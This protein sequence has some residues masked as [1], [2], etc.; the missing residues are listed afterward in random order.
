MSIKILAINPGGT[1][2]KIGF[3]EDNQPVF[4][5]TIEH[6]SEEL[7]RFKHANNQLDMRFNSIYDALLKN[8]VDVSALTACVGRGGFLP[9]VEAGGYRVNDLMID[10]LLNRCELEHASSLGAVLADRF[11]QL[12]K[13]RAHAYIYDAE[14]LN[15]LPP[16]ARI[17]GV[18]S[19]ERISLCHVLNMRAVCRRVAEALNSRYED[20]NFIIIHMGGGTS[21]SAHNKGR[22]IEAMPDD[23]GPF[24]VERSGAIANKYIVNMCY[25]KPMAEVFTLLRKN[26]GV[27]SYLGTNDGREVEQM[28]ADGDQYA[29][30]IYEAMSYQ[31]ARATGDMYAVLEG[32][33]DGI[34]LTGGL[35]KSQ[36]MCSMIQKRVEFMAPVHVVP[37]EYELEALAEGAYR[38]VTNQEEA[39][40]Y[41]E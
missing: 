18:K 17:S 32:Q 38:I 40:E 14:S 33:V 28:I 19:I 39:R 5:K 31:I 15:Q 6:D 35:A 21:V 1:S 20:M 9:P 30:L 16:I 10:F 34:I 2:T 3:F 29:K 8:H 24:S 13:P 26:G 12:S 25:Q 36:L 11:A 4:S 22:V 41:T 7:K 23:E 27:K 37:G